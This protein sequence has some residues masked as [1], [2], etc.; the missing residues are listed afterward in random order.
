MASQDKNQQSSTLL[1]GIVPAA[2]FVT[3]L[4]TSAGGKV[5]PNKHTLSGDLPEVK[6]T[7]APAPADSATKVLAPAEPETHEAAH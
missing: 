2:V 4:F 7:E 6:K 1:W 3:L 5:V